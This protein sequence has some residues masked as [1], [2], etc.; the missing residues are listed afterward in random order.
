RAVFLV[1]CGASVYVQNQPPVAISF[2]P[3]SC[4]CTYQTFTLNFSD[5]NG[6]AD[7]YYPEVI[8]NTS[9]NGVNACFVVYDRLNN[10][11]LLVNDPGTGSTAVTLGSAGSAQN[12][13]CTLYGTGSSAV[14]AGN[15]Q[16]ITL[17][18]GFKPAFY[19]SKNIYLYTA[20][21]GGL[22]A[23]NLAG[24]WDPEASVAV[25]PSTISATPNSGSGSS[26]TF[27]FAFFDPNGAADLS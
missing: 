4:S 2:S 6:Y 26:A 3:S 12:N 13:Q 25:P 22:T 27:S 1:A 15:N 8:F 18:L 7:L 16:S 19:G 17:N 5:P 14:S 20:D 21:A 24:Q 23:A 11:A 9:F 10:R